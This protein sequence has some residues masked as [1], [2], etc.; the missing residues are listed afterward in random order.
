MRH[1]PPS[2]SLA[3]RIARFAKI[4]VDDLLTD[5]FPPPE[6]ARTA[7]EADR[8][9]TVRKRR[10][11]RTPQAFSQRLRNHMQLLYKTSPH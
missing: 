6:P 3:L 10:Q 7:E 4:T 1:V 2:A 11:L 5:K 8:W 9:M